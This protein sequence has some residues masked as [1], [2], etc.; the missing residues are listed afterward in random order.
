MI[1][2]RNR[3]L[4]MP[5]NRGF[6]IIEL[7]VVI[8]LMGLAGAVIIPRLLE[9]S[10][11]EITSAQDG[12]IA[13]IRAAQQAAVGRANVTFQI[14]SDGNDWTFAAMSGATPLRTFQVPTDNVLLETGSAAS[15]GNTCATGFDTAVAGDFSL[16]FKNDGGLQSFTNNA[17][18]EN[19]NGSFNGVRICLN[20]TDAVS[21]CV[22]PA[23]YAYAG[24]CD[25]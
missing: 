16:D 6:T 4:S 13:T 22:S 1:W 11:F 7:I 21:A 10:T 3:Y 5:L 12:M 19:V 23:G 8:V 25:D 20:D 24:N 9:P 14:T 15:S 17:S 18:T 2:G